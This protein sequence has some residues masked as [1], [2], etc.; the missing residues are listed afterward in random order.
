VKTISNDSQK[1][2]PDWGLRA[3]QLLGATVCLGVWLGAVGCGVETSNGATPH[4]THRK[5]NAA[6]HGP[7]V[8][9]ST[10]SPLI[11]NVPHIRQE[12][13][14]CGEACLAMALAKAGKTYSQHDV[15]NLSG[16]DPIHGRGA[17]TREM[18]RAIENVGFKKSPVWTTVKVSPTATKAS[19]S[20]MV[21]DLKRGVPS[22]VCMRYAPGTGS[23]EHFRLILGYDQ[24][25][26]QV[27]YHEPAED[28][29]AYRRMDR[30]RFESLWPLKYAM[31]RWTLIRFPLDPD[32]LK[33]PPAKHTGRTNAD[34]A[35]HILKLKKTLPN[36]SFSIVLEKPFVVVGDESAAT[37]RRRA[38]GTIRWATKNLKAS[39]F[40]KDPKHVL[41]IWLFKDKTSYDTHAK[42]LW[43]SKPHTPYGYFSS[44]HK[45]LVMN[46]STGGG[47]LVHEI[48]HPFVAANFPECPAWFNEGLGSLYEQCGERNKKIV[49]FTNW[50]LANLKKA[51]R[52]DS[53]SSLK[54][55]CA[56]TT[57][58]FYSGKDRGNNYA[59]ARYLLYELQQRGELRAYYQKFYAA[60]AKDPTGYKTLMAVLGQTDQTMPAFE[61][62]WQKR[63]LKLTYP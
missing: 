40:K 55:L 2:G 42:S 44:F 48:V 53:L 35:Q 47:T 23:P 32:A 10:G 17:V 31:D 50:R 1:T 51:I 28:N 43:G 45:A 34:Y 59:Q 4:P 7:T 61:A 39:Y 24:A 56:T 41:T 8:P 5:P 18:K 37:V 60:R 52:A 63:V 11:A 3:K 22:I 15:F 27:I 62:A 29:G 20:A 21:A 13:D 49:G 36:K 9:V 12:P 6:A 57:N 30:T 16:T 25:K 33:N 54:T 46:I 58:E 19:F 14:F 26:Q 38:A